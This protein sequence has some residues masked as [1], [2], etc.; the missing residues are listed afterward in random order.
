[1]HER[2]PIPAGAD[3]NFNQ[4]ARG[5]GAE[6][7]AEVP[8]AVSGLDAGPPR[9]PG[10]VP[11]DVG[12]TMTTGGDSDERASPKGQFEETVGLDLG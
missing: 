11:K 8:A 1:M 6:D 7:P 2:D 3:A 5:G 4:G 12:T 9:S 10:A